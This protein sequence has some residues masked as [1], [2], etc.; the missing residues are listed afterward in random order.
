MRRQSN[1]AL[2][3]VGGCALAIAGIVTLVVST[4]EP[5]EEE[6]KRSGPSLTDFALPGV[7][8]SA[9]SPAPAP[10]GSQAPGRVQMLPIQVDGRP[11]LLVRYETSVLLEPVQQR[12]AQSILD[13]VKGQAEKAGAKV[14]V[15]M[16]VAARTSKKGTPVAAQTHTV[17][18]ERAVDGTWV[19][20]EEPTLPSGPGSSLPVAAI[21]PSSAS[22]SAAPAS[23]EVPLF[24]TH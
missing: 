12:A 10:A 23:S 14:V 15:I 21:P 16:A 5:E 3:V 24:I 7:G 13:K 18:F 11:G 17:A 1:T 9:S 4:K 2:Y 20:V 22:G 8:A 6:E 19:Q